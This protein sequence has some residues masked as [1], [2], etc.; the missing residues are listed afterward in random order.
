M[1]LEIRLVDEG[2]IGWSWNFDNVENE[3]MKNF[4][5]LMVMGKKIWVAFLLCLFLVCVCA[6]FFCKLLDMAMLQ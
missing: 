4:W 5:Q 6:L 3:K 1:W 2:L